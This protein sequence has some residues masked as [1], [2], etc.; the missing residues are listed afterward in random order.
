MF[1][2]VNK[3]DKEKN[4]KIEALAKTFAEKSGFTKLLKWNRPIILCI[5]G[6]ILNAFNGFI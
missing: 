5:V 6:T 2:Q 1:D 3:T 4:E